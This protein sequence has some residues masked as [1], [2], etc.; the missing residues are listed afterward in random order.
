MKRLH[1]WLFNLA[2]VV[3]AVLCIAMVF[4][5]IRSFSRCDEIIWVGAYPRPEGPGYESVELRSVVG[6]LSLK[7]YRP[8]P[9]YMYGTPTR[10]NGGRLGV[11]FSSGMIGPN[12]RPNWLS[13]VSW[14]R[15]EPLN[16]RAPFELMW[17]L[18]MPHW[19]PAAA[20]GIIPLIAVR[21]WRRAHR[22]LRPGMCAKC[23]YDLR[24]TPHR[25]PECGTISE[26]AKEAAT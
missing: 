23:G 19:L 18:S 15:D 3:S 20:F 13:F 22:Q 1:H 21:R 8:R 2:T 14:D 11:G 9:F 17:G 25:C 12:L 4:L 10:P 26:V 16:P 6:R 5:W 24:A 7:Y